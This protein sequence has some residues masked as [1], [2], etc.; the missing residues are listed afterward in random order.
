MTNYEVLQKLG[1]QLN[2]TAAAKLFEGADIVCYYPPEEGHRC[3]NHNGQCD[4]C[5]PAW[6]DENATMAM[7]QFLDEE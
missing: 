7:L 2:K 3:H 1:L 4:K 5:V 6:L